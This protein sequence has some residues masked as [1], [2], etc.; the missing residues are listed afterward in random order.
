M[1]KW[2]EPNPQL[3]SEYVF[4]VIL[5]KVAFDLVAFQ[6]KTRISRSALKLTHISNKWLPDFFPEGK[7]SGC[8]VDHWPR[9]STKF[10]NMW[11]YASTPSYVLATWTVI[12]LSFIFKTFET[13]LSKQWF[14]KD[15]PSFILRYPHAINTSLFSCSGFWKRRIAADIIELNFFLLQDGDKSIPRK[16]VGLLAWDDGQCPKCQLRFLPLHLTIRKVSVDLQ[17]AAVAS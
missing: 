1:G 4:S 10:K 5:W 8:H 11:S 17:S 2:T 7:R 3:S 13:S 12:T 15:K 14:Y 9:S 16:V 6:N